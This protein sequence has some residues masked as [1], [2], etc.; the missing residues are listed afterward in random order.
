MTINQ[1][2]KMKESVTK[3]GVTWAMVKG[4]QTCESASAKGVMPFV[5]HFNCLYNG[6]GVVPGH[7]QEYGHCTADS[8]Y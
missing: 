6:K 8:C 5:N 2:L 1:E 3:S 7:R 4:C